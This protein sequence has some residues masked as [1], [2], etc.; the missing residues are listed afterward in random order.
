MTHTRQPS[1]QEA[2]EGDGEFQRSL[3]TSATL[4]DPVLYSVLETANQ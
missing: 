4:H 1:S 3:N 2:E